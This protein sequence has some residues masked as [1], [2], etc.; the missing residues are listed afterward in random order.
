MSMIRKVIPMQATEVAENR[1]RLIAATSQLARDGHV[2]EPAGMDISSFLRIGTILFDHDPKVPVGIPVSGGL[3]S[4]G[5]LEVEIEWAPAGISAK[6][7]EVRGLVKAGILRTGSVGFEPLDGEPLD[8]A[9]PRGG[10]HITKSEL[11]E[12]SI[13]AVP[14]DT[15]AVVTQRSDQSADW[16]CGV[17]RDLP[18]EDSD[19]W[20]GSAAEASIFEWAGGDDFD[21]SKARKGFLA[22]N[23]T[24]PKERGSYKLPIAHVVDGRLKVPKGAIRAAASRLPQADI[25]DTVKETAKGVIAHYEEKA[26]MADKDRGIKVKHTRALERAPKVPLFKRGLCEVASL[27]YTLSQLGY[28]HD[29]AEWEADCEGD[30]SPVPGMLGEALVALGKAFISMA[31]EEAKELLAAKD[32]E[33][34]DDEIPVAERAYVAAAKTPQTRAWRLGVAMARAGKALSATNEKKLQDAQENHGRAL[35]HHKALGDHQEAVAGNMDAITSQQEKATKAH[36]ELGEALQGVK[37]EPEKATEHVARAVKAH[38]ALGGALG[39]MSDASASMKDSHADATDA[40]AAVGRYV[41]SAQR[42]VRGVVEGSTT[43]AEDDDGD[44]KNVQTSSGT[45]ES[46][47][48]SNDRSLDYRRR[49]ADLQTLAANLT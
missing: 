22:Y 30:D 19:A 48:S 3:N 16:K 14:A 36:G 28:A 8:P 10:Q 7:D 21:P 24:K 11:L 49:Q 12:L 25:P 20:D 45:G 1:T 15:G 41:K 46:G 29:C 32:L 42:C 33:I 6:A 5:D 13:V 31:D 18:I 43:A 4:A 35:K 40:H 34:E 9:K 26:G 38:K 39:D 44:S 47:G 37:N 27:A 23:A 2:L 17:S